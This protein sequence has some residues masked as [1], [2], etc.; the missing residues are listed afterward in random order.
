MPIKKIVTK[1]LVLGK[2]FWIN[3]VSMETKSYN[4]LKVGNHGNK[5]NCKNIVFDTYKEGNNTNIDF[6]KIV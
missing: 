3:V 1:I 6:W 4:Q 2:S 5:Q